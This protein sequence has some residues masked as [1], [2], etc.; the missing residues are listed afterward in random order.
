MILKGVPADNAP[1]H[2]T[3]ASPALLYNT[4]EESG[5]LTLTASDAEGVQTSMPVHSPILKLFCAYFK[6][7]LGERYAL[8]S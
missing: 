4:R 7:A 8:M 5:D 1:F 3:P 2:H 6:T